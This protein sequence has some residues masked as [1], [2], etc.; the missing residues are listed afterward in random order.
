VA[1]TL[2]HMQLRWRQSLFFLVVLK[3]RVGRAHE[4][5]NQFDVAL[6]G[7]SHLTLY[8]DNMLLYSVVFHVAQLNAPV[9][10]CQSYSLE[11]I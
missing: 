1:A 6:S 7:E 10:L 2:G 9:E 5:K 4:T 11:L 3:F 8:V